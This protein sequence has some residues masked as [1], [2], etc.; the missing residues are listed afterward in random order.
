MNVFNKLLLIAL[1]TIWL[2]ACSTAPKTQ[3]PLDSNAPI[4]W[5]EHKNH[6]TQQNEFKAS[7]K[8]AVKQ[9]DKR[10]SA[11][12]Q[13]QQEGDRYHIFITGPLGSGAITIT[14]SPHEV[15]MDISGEGRFYASSP[16]A[17]MKQRLGWSIP[18]NDL[19]YWAKGIP[20][21]HSGYSHSLNDNGTLS[22]LMQNQWF[23]EYKNY[24]T[25]NKTDWPRKMQLH[26][27]ND[28][29]VTLLIK[30]WEFPEKTL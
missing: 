29:Q 25:L 26:Y 15:I 11:S 3:P 28:I 10:N 18:I 12:L 2:T 9:G 20:A 6:L 4:S 1:S 22:Q 24:H 14:G 30:Q 16:E 21:P 7:G 8:L 23:I 5:T 19:Q 17:L 13:W 27:G